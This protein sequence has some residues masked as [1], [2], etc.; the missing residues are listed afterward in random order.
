MG[1]SGGELLEDAV[2]STMVLVGDMEPSDALASAWVLIL[3]ICGG[4][5][6][7]SSEKPAQTGGRRGGEEGMGRAAFIPSLSGE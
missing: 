5:E 3:G 7:K 4:S 2:R 6:S 1:G